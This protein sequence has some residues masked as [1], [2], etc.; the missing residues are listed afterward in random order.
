MLPTTTSSLQTNNYHSFPNLP[1]LAENAVTRL[2]V[3]RHGQ[4]DWNAEG[5]LQGGSHDVPLNTTGLQQA[6]AVA[7]VLTAI[8]AKSDM[9]VVSSPLA[10]A[11]ETADVIAQRFQQR[12]SASSVVR[13]I[14]PKFSEMRFGTYWEGRAIRGPRATDSDKATF[15]DFSRR[16]ATE[17]PTLAWPGGGESLDDVRRRGRAGLTQ[18]LRDFGRKPNHQICL[19]AHGRFNKILLQDLLGL[20]GEALSQGNACI[21]VVDIL[22]AEPGGELRCQAHVLNHVQHLST[23]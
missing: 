12:G 20:T 4:T 18:V 10:R 17:D 21:N 7:N 9:V 23:E 14:H 8:N 5:R 2:W 3:V 6:A 16:M 1:P 11:A 22:Q 13:I 19:V 15:R